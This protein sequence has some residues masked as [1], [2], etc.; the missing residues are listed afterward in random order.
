MAANCPQCSNPVFED[1][2]VAVCSNCHSVLFIDMDGN[3]SITEPHQTL[4]EDTANSFSQ[5]EPKSEGDVGY[6]VDSNSE[7]DLKFEELAKF[8]QDLP[9]E[10]TSE[11]ST[12]YRFT[13]QNKQIDEQPAEI[14]KTETNSFASP[15][16]NSLPELPSDLSAAD[17]EVGVLSYDLLIENID[18]K[19]IRSQ[20][21][22]I[23]SEPK[24]H[25]DAAELLKKI[26]MGKLRLEN[27]NAA[28]AS[29]LVQKISEMPVKVSWKQNAFN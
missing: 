2:G 29:V 14:V 1:F 20:L 12:S 9:L 24:F 8:E 25:W 26:K 21:Q 6:E 17:M 23:F 7:A 3:A 10:P 22:D 18:T 13:D 27:I 16:S 28:K 19:E 15:E 5:P 4:L 11:Q